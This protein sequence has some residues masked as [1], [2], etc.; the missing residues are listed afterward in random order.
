[1]EENIENFEKLSNEDLQE[2]EKMVRQ[3]EL[4]VEINGDDESSKKLIE[5]EEKI[6]KLHENLNS[7][8]D[9]IKTLEHQKQ[10]F[11]KELIQVIIT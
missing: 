7:K 2:T 6:A 1:M 4:E 11:E 3:E 8:T 5:A 9:F 10:H